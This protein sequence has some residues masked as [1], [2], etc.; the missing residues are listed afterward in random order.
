MDFATLIGLIIGT[1]IIAMAVL[2]G[3]DP[4]IF[5]NAPGLLIV[6]GG[7]FAATLIKFPLTACAQAFSLAVKTAFWEE[8]DSPESLIAEANSMIDIVRKQN[9]LALEGHEIKNPFLSIGVRLSIDGRKPDFIRKVLAKVME[10][11][12]ER[13]LLGEKIFRGIGDSAPAFGMI[14]T[15]VGLVQMLSNM[16]D[17]SSIGPAMAVALLTTLYGALFA[18]LVA[19]PIADK[20]RIRSDQEY[21][22]KSLIIESVSSIQKGENPRIMDELL[23]AYLPTKLRR[24]LAVDNYEGVERRCSGERRCS[25]RRDE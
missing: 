15:L 25:E 10:Q 24:A 18:N 16:Q 20:L 11:S 21:L 7:T 1:I 6:L 4:S 8:S 14:G 13:H 23:E 9:L 22:Q 12:I 5:V 2:S 3:S 17:P 19:N